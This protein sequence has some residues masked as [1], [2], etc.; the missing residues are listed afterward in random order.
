MFLFLVLKSNN[1]LVEDDAYDGQKPSLQADNNRRTSKYMDQKY[2]DNDQV[3]SKD[4]SILFI[5]IYY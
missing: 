1:K 5:K 2:S 4:I 3:V